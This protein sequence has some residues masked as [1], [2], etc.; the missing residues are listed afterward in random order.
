MKRRIA[1][2]S[3]LVLSLLLLAGCAQEEATPLPDTM[4]QEAVL[5]A[6]E[7]VLNQLLAGE[8]EAVY[9]TFRDDIR[10]DLTVEEV[11]NL[12]EPVFQ[13]AGDFEKIESAGAEGSAEGEEHAIAEFRLNC[14]E[15]DVLFNAAF[16]LEMELI[17]LSA[18]LDV[19]EWSFDNLA[20]N[21]KELFGG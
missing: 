8:Y 3:A 18:G 5:A 14:A 21:V 1:A 2:L 6:G 12:V 10:A 11:Q 20:G 16:D 15:E 7:E 13:E 17:G 9:E 4:D 19:R